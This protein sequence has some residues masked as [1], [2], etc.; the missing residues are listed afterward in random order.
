MVVVERGAAMEQKV[1]QPEERCIRVY[2][3]GVYDVLHSGHMRQ[4]KQAK[5]LFPNTYVLVGVASDE[6]TRRLKGP[7]V[8]SIEERAESLTHLKWVDEVIAPCPWVITPSFLKEYRI[9]YVAHDDAPYAAGSTDEAD[10][11]YGW[12]KRENKFRA[13]VRTS[14]V[15]TTDL[16]CRIIADYETYVERCLQRGVSRRDLN[17][18]FVGA[19]AMHAK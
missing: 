8:M 6:D 2:S 1:G 12:L 10:D 5:M 14:G 4:L 9:D 17:V 19:Q 11:I 3:D 7:T 13:T 18:S 16:I 15:S